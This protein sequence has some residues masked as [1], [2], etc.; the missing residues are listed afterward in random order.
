MCYSNFTT[1]KFV[2]TSI[3]MKKNQLFL[4]S[5]RIYFS[6]QEKYFPAITPPTYANS[7]ILLIIDASTLLF[8]KSMINEHQVMNFVSLSRNFSTH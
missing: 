6:S 7:L 8:L 4:Y 2:A 5:L 1:S 3:F